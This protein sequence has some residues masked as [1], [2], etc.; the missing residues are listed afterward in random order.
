MLML[1]SSLTAQDSL[2]SKVY[3]NSIGY[4]LNALA[5]DPTGHVVQVGST[6]FDYA[7]FSYLDSLGNIISSS[8]YLID[9][10]PANSFSFTQAVATSGN[11]YFVSGGVVLQNVGA[12]VG[13]VAKL[14][15]QGVVSWSKG[16]YTSA[17]GFFKCTD[18]IESA[19]QTLWVVGS[20]EQTGETAI[21]EFDTDGVQLAAFSFKITGERL[22]IKDLKE[23]G[24]TLIFTGSAYATSGASRGIVFATEKDGTFL[25]SNTLSDSKFFESE[26]NENSIWAAGY[27]GTSHPFTMSLSHDGSI[28]ALNKYEIVQGPLDDLDLARIYDSTMVITLGNFFQSTLIKARVNSPEVFSYGISNNSVEVVSRENNGFYIGGFGPNIGVKSLLF[29]DPHSNMIR[30]D[31]SVSVQECVYSENSEAISNST[32]AN[33]PVTLSTLS[34]ASLSVLAIVQVQNNLGEVVS[35][36]DYYSGI[37]E[38]NQSLISLYPNPGNGN[39][40]IANPNG[41]KGNLEIQNPSG[42]TVF[43]TNI[44]SSE[45]TMDLNHLPAGVYFFQ[46]KT[47]DSTQIS[48]GKLIVL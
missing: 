25:W 32:P 35:C 23:W 1:S 6:D 31:S 29:P 42:E 15:N 27:D 10:Q 34:P 43:K 2:Y 22:E 11:E 3:Y 5:V 20:D 28:R 48:S 4:Q 26:M 19:E 9:G 46:F 33:D 45:Q 39:I 47:A 14:D 30:V 16:V 12:Y 21:I 40:Q 44:T 37:N 7:A 17:P 41:M 8:K 36:V 24:D 38:L 18:I 13:L